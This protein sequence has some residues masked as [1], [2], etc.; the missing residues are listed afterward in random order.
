MLLENTLDCY[1]RLVQLA[2]AFC[3]LTVVD[4]TERLPTHC[5]F[6]VGDELVTCTFHPVDTILFLNSYTRFKLT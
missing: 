2:A 5:P 3:K 1:W 6:F 4:Y